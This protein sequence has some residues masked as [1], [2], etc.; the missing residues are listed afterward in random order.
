VAAEAKPGIPPIVSMPAAPPPAKKPESKPQGAAPAGAAANQGGDGQAYCSNIAP[1]VID[2]RFAWQAKRLAEL[3][4]QLKQR[5]AE[6][7][8]KQTEYKAWLQKREE[9]Q[10]KAE[11]NVV[12]IYSRMRP[13]ASA[14]QLAAMD[15]PMA[16]AILS[17]LNARAAGAI[18][19]EMDAAK[20]ARLAD[21]IAGKQPP[22]SSGKKS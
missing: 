18:L 21:T 3:E 2:A 13:E 4:A 8:A 22:P 14:A 11:D 17:K 6:L 7:D 16:A 10:K 5:M 20:A 9:F 1:T 12:A 15:E 19:N